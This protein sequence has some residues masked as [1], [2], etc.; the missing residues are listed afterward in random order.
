MFNGNK[1]WLKRLCSRH[2][3]VQFSDAWIIKEIGR[4]GVWIVISNFLE[5][6]KDIPIR[7]VV[8]IP[9]KLPWIFPGAPLIFNGAAGNIQGNLTGMYSWLYL[10]HIIPRRNSVHCDYSLILPT[11]LYQNPCFFLKMSPWWRHSRLWLHTRLSFSLQP[12]TF[13][14]QDCISLSVHTAVKHIKFYK[15]DPLYSKKKYEKNMERKPP[16]KRYKLLEGLAWDFSVMTCDIAQ[17]SSNHDSQ[18]ASVTRIWNLDCVL[19][20]FLYQISE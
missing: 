19:I 11:N 15:L 5:A 14:Q 10:A 16:H 9:V 2:I 8:H 6:S 17:G 13:R 12:G 18:A 20:V 4:W 7:R 3:F 1:I